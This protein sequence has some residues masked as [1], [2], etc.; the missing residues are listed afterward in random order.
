MSN[1]IAK[2]SLRVEVDEPSLE[3][4]LIFTPEEDGE[5]WDAEKIK[6]LIASEKISEGYNSGSIDSI[7]DDW[8]KQPVKRGDGQVNTQT[9]T[10]A[11]GKPAE[12]PV[13]EEAVWEEFSRPEESISDIERFLQEADA[14]RIT[15]EK[16]EKV[17]VKRKVQKKQKLPFLQPKEEFEEITEKR[18]VE[19]PVDVDPTVVDFGWAE[20]GQKLAG[21]IPAKPGKPGKDVFGTPIMPLSETEPAVYPGR[22]TEKSK[23]DIIAAEA[24]IVRRGRNWVEVLPFR[25]HEWSVHLSKDKATCYLSF[26]PGSKH[27]TPPTPGK[28]VEEIKKLEYPEELVIPLDEIENLILQSIEEG[29]ELHDVV[30]S[31]DSDA[32]VDVH[33][34]EDNLKATL[35][36]R[37]GRGKGKPLELKEVGKALRESGIKGFNTENIKKDIMDFYRSSKMVLSDYPLAEGTPP[38]LPEDGKLSFNVTFFDESEREEM[39]ERLAASDESQFP[40]I[41]SFNDFH[42]LEVEEMGFVVRH[43][44]VAKIEKGKK[45]R[46]GKDVYGNPVPAAE[47]KEVALQLYENVRMEQ[48]TAQAEVG[49]LI[50]KGSRAGTVLLRIRPHRDSEADVTVSEDK[51]RAYLSLRPAEGIGKQPDIEL[52]KKKLAENGVKQGINQDASVKAVEAA[53][54]GEAVTNLLIAKGKQPQHA[55][56]NKLELFVQLPSQKNVTIKKDGRADYKNRHNMISVKAG[57]LIAK[58]LAPET[59]PED[60]WDV[61]GKT[62]S[63]KKTKGF[64]LQIGKNIKQEI[65]D[66]GSTNLI[67]EKDGKLLY[68][69][70]SMEIQDTHVVEGNV[71]LKSGNIKFK[72]TVQVKGSVETGFYVVSG[73]SIQIKEGV[74]AALLSCEKDIEIGQGVKGG[75]KAVLRTKKNIKAAFVERAT[76]LTVGDISIKNFCLQS[77]VKCN[78]KL[79]L[80]SE[81]GSFIGGLVKARKGLDVMNLGAKNGIKTEVFFGQDYLVADQIEL[82]EKEIEKIKNKILEFDTAMNRLEKKGDKMKLEQV[83]KEKLKLLKIM[84]KRSFRLFN[85]RERF[86]EHFPSEVQIRGTLYPGVVVESHGRYYEPKSEKKALKLIFDEESGQIKEEP[87]AKK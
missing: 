52:I 16:T 42:V 87:I 43:Q 1:T 57:E 45:G 81:K 29:R 32:T 18:K 26:S 35:D 74:E 33:V 75:G 76:V 70:K 53:K 37:K 48:G 14:P 25:M 85:F 9:V 56:E 72:G 20:K 50:E 69:K 80:E 21:I 61:T 66:D 23:S 68:D 28:I 58:I 39:K 4:R 51:M 15:K 71:D 19:E 8:A 82:E 67:A 6:R 84:E 83:R 22:G 59:E 64:D 78:G 34:T 17:K 36:I 79:F 41:N 44:S 12:D 2:G 5:E 13:P 24:G 31:G 27:S 38:E 46:D 10:I 40:G 47:P 86:E 11:A 73:D 55:G 54:K 77:N 60:G 62:I 63:A 30:I 7:A 49:G 65:Q 3:A